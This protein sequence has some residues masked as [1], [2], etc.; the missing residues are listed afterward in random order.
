MVEAAIQYFETA[1]KFNEL[2]GGIEK[3][4]IARKEYAALQLHTEITIIATC[5]ETL[6][7]RFGM[8]EKFKPLQLDREELLYRIGDNPVTSKAGNFNLLPLLK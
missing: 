2:I 1:M 7:S 3:Y 5:A 8:S 4:G 6:I